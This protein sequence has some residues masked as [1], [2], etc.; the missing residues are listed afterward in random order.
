MTLTADYRPGHSEATIGG[1]WY[2]AFLLED[3][4]LAITIGDVVGKGLDAAVTMGKVRQAMRS[5]A[6]LLPEPNAML[7]AAASAVRDVS[8]DNYAT[9]MAGIFEPRTHEF[10]FA[11]AGHPGP[12]VL[13]PGGG[14]H[15][16]TAR[17]VMLGLRQGKANETVT[18]SASPGS[19]L[20]FFTDGLIEAT[21]NVD[22]G[23][24]RLHAAMSD[25]GVAASENRARAL[26]D[27][28]LRGRAAMDDI[29]VLVAEVGPSGTRA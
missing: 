2:D 8:S 10:T 18:I 17:G 3:R 6:A 25:N 27:H 28:V 19:V 1:D 13:S 11:C 15:D 26:V 7:T 20:V 22:E 16:H 5:A 24:R 29:A 14:V 9:A 23:Y 4:R 12:T 21:R